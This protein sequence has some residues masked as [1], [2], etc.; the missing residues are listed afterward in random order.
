MKVAIYHRRSKLSKEED[1]TSALTVMHSWADAKKYEVHNFYADTADKLDEQVRLKTLIDDSKLGLFGMVVCISPITLSNCSWAN[2]V[3]LLDILTPNC[4]VKF[5]SWM[6]VEVNQV[7][8]MI[9]TWEDNKIE[10]HRRMMVHRSI[11]EQGGRPKKPF[12]LEEATRLRVEEGLTYKQIGD[13]LQVSS[14]LIFKS[15]PKSAKVKV[16]KDLRLR[17]RQQERDRRDKEK[18]EVKE[19]R[20]IQ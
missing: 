16:S 20:R 7:M 9:K 1:T 4:G 17:L 2:F 14:G 10:E 13:R 15:L 19:R 3:R 8:A 5:V 6:G 12:D 18:Q 11:N